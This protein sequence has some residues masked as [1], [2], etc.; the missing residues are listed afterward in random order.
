MS[1]FHRFW[2]ISRYWPNIADFNL[3][4][5]YLAPNFGWC[6]WNF[7]KLTEFLLFN[8]NVVVIQSPYVN[9]QF[10]GCCG[11]YTWHNFMNLSVAWTLSTFGV[12]FLR[13]WQLF[14]ARF[15][16]NCLAFSLGEIAAGQRRVLTSVVYCRGIGCAAASASGLVRCGRVLVS[17]HRRRVSSCILVTCRHAMRLRAAWLNPRTFAANNTLVYDRT[18]AFIDQTCSLSCIPSRPACL[19]FL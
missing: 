14:V 15:L 1:V 2:D 6:H 10:T 7:T 3:L 9:S 4:H 18:R 17:G 13:V 5:L 19:S 16:C 12:C 8:D 11:L